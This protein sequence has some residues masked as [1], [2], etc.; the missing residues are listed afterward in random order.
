MG[1]FPSPGATF[2]SSFLSPPPDLP[3]DIV[4]SFLFLGT[5]SALK[6]VVEKG[7]QRSAKVFLGSG[8]RSISSPPQEKFFWLG[9]VTEMGYAGGGEEESKGFAVWPF[10]LSVRNN[11]VAKPFRL[12]ENVFTEPKA[13]LFCHIVTRVH[14][15][16]HLKGLMSLPK[17]GEYFRIEVIL[18]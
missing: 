15:S 2:L 4:P 14:Y 7:I 10:S 8:P 16:I 17:V 12:R 9:G 5:N 3:I 13:M 18:V 6:D 11:R 1:L